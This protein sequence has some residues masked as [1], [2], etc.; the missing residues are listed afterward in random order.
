MY[1]MTSNL[2]DLNAAG[3]YAQVSYATQQQR[4]INMVPYAYPMDQKLVSHPLEQRPVI[5][6][7][8]N[9]SITL[10][11]GGRGGFSYSPSTSNTPQINIPPLGVNDDMVYR[12]N[13]IAQLQGNYE[14]ETPAGIDQVS[15]IVPSLAK[16][17]LKYAIVRRISSNGV[18][19]VD[20][21][22]YEKQSFF[23]LCSD[24][25]VEAV[26]MKGSNMKHS[27][28]WE[29]IGLGTSTVWRRKGEVTFNLFQVQVQSPTPPTRNSG[30]QTPAIIIADRLNSMGICSTSPSSGSSGDSTAFLGPN[31]IPSE[32]QR[33]NYMPTIAPP[34]VNRSSASYATNANMTPLANFPQGFNHSVSHVYNPKQ[35][36][37][38]GNTLSESYEPTMTNASNGSRDVPCTEHQQAMFELIKAH[39]IR[40]P[41]LLK[42]LVQWGVKDIGSRR[43]SLNDA[44]NL[45]KGRLWVAAHPVQDGEI[46][47]SV[48]E[49][50]E[51]IKGAYREVK[52]GE[53]M[54]PQPLV[55]E[56]GVQHRLIKSPDGQWKIEAHDLKSGVWNLCAQELPDGRW[57][58]MKNNRE[59]IFVQLIPMNLILKKIVDGR[60]AKSQEVEKCMEFLFTFCNQKKL[61][62]KLKGRNLRHNIDNLKVKLEKQ[63]SLC[64]AVQV[65]NTADLIAK[66]LEAIR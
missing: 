30:T 53:Y 5:L 49:N 61:N 20:R 16:D 65:A 63:Y 34:V 7:A 54:Q 26:M 45:A 55:S 41:C 14:I 25:V 28:K 10:P 35:P 23:T 57:V 3:Q 38:E 43:F 22:I 42:K 62:S 52:S 29:D 9:P 6:G 37:K 17:D 58:D 33:Q 47:S 59:E 60:V 39:C 24:G 46:E 1:R 4:P 44:N 36:H 12:C 31:S 21:I 8:T 11:S 64:F 19:L 40:K 48:Q 32:L 50:L 27:V 66:E 15:V 13:I 18:A 51:D 56:P 2:P